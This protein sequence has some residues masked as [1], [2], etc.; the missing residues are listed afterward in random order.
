[1]NPLVVLSGMPIA[2]LGALGSRCALF[3]IAHGVADGGPYAREWQ[4][5]IHDVRCGSTLRGVR[6]GVC[7]P[8]RGSSSTG[9]TSYAHAFDA[10]LG[11]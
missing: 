6:F 5:L 2:A 10:A 3:G 9:D 4:P 11:A 7:R 8:Q 1:M